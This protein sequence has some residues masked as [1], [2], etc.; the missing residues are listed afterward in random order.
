M[1]TLI[2]VKCLQINAFDSCVKRSF[3]GQSGNHVFAVI[4]ASVIIFKDFV[5]V[6]WVPECYL[7]KLVEVLLIFEEANF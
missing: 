4:F 2:A 5:I 1:A 3:W 7:N 6:F